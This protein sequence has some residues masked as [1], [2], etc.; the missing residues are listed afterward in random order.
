MLNLNRNSHVPW[1]SAFLL[2]ISYSIANGVYLTIE[3]VTYYPIF[4]S[5]FTSILL[6][7]IAASFMTFYNYKRYVYLIPLSLLSFLLTSITPLILLLPIAYELRKISSIVGISLLI[8]SSSMLS[9][10]FL[11]LIANVN[12]YFSL[13]LMLITAG[14]PVLIPIVWFIGIF[15]LFMPNKKGNK[16][17]ISLNPLIPFILTLLVSL[18]PYLPS[19]NPYKFPETVDFKYYYS[20]LLHPQFD[21]WFFYT[22]PFYLIL[23]YLLSLIFKPYPV[24]FY[25]FV[26]LSVFY[27]YSG[28]KLASALD[29]SIASLAALLASVSPMLIT[30]L[31]SGL[32]ANLFSI[33]LM[34]LSMYYLIKKE[35]ITLA[36]ILSLLS[37][38]SH[39]Y[40]WAQISTA[41][42]LYYVFRFMVS[43]IKPS[44]YEVIYLSSSLPFIFTGL[45]LIFMGIFPVPMSLANYNDLIY[46]IA[47]GSWGSSNMLLFFIIT[48]LGNRFMKNLLGFIYAI[49]VLG[50]LVIQPATNLIIDL[51]LF[52]PAAYALRYIRKDIAILLIINLVLWGIY[53][54]INSVPKIH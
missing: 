39:I 17:P 40:A 11:R 34:F 7:I 41:I 9:W 29:R 5:D 51:P 32:E 36:I 50:T 43:K 22:R 33:S 24:A 1:I 53:M 49:S 16:D 25:E 21:G 35:K 30:F 4:K 15:F 3:R 48:M 19:I 42:I 26:F 52:I 6:T 14:V 47:V 18:L 10:I 27:V 2:I 38:L 20:W 23:L 31:Y 8:T 46:Q 54:S 37:M 28:Y 45:L 44:K 12:T 13:P